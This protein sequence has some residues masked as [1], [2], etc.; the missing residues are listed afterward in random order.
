MK[1]YTINLNFKSNRKEVLRILEK[2]F[3]DLK[4][5]EVK[6]DETYSS[7]NFYTIT[8][9]NGWKLRISIG[10]VIISL[11]EIISPDDVHFE[12]N[13]ETGFCKNFLEG[14]FSFD[15]P[16][17]WL[18]KTAVIMRKFNRLTIIVKKFKEEEKT[19][20]GITKLNKF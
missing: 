1:N 6:Y 15:D 13:G 20:E 8:N 4:K 14:L 16:Y 19:F 11:I 12:N 5:L 3:S 7:A 18:G 10:S 9:E 2:Y 17:F